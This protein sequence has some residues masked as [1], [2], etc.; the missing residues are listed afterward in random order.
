MKGKVI[1]KKKLYYQIGDKENNPW[2]M[3]ELDYIN[4]ALSTGFD[5]TKAKKLKV[6]SDSQS[7]Y[8]GQ[9]HGHEGF[10]LTPEEATEMIVSSSKNSE[11][12]FPYLTGDNFL[13]SIPPQPQRYVIDFHPREINEAKKYKHP[14]QRVK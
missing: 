14:F 6:N 5:V 11:V 9:T 7:C 13:S 4:S 1:G 10:L 12:I 2:E 3:I 8:Q